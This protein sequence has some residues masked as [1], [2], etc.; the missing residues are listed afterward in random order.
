VAVPPDRASNVTK[1]FWP[2][3]GLTKGDLLDYLDAVSSLMIPALRDRPLT[4][5]RYPDGV[6]AFS[7]FQKNT[8]EHAPSFVKTVRIHA[9]S[10]KRDVRYTVCNSKRTLLWLGNQAAIEFHPWTARVDRL[11]RPDVMV[12]DFD[13]PDDGFDEAVE[14]ALAMREVLD[15]A[16]L[17][18]AAKTSGSK[19]IHVYVPLRRRHGFSVVAR[20]AERLGE[21]L[22]ERRPRLT[23]MEFSKANREG[24][25]LID[26]RR[27]APAQ[28]TVAA[29]SP[30]ARPHATVSFPVRW[31]DLG[32]VRT[33][34]FTIRTVP[35]LVAGGTDLW[36]ELLPAA[37]AIPPA[38][39]ED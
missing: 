39:V 33:E 34:D 10:A 37:Q 12:F 11:D 2:D 27:N 8:P 3:A 36:K 38:L 17:H 30:R 18:G 16:G 35:A 19:G 4:V 20:A 22:V 21:R 15:D 1:V 14:A 25:V 29:Y 7:F 26:V 32:K 9:G 6:E 5:K 28:H 24:R 13:P 31:E 23:N